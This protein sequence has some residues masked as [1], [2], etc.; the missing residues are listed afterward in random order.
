MKEFTPFQIIVTGLFA[1]LAVIGLIVFATSQGGGK[2]NEAVGTVVIWGTLPTEVIEDGIATLASNQEAYSDVVYV[3]QPAASFSKNLSDALASGTGPDLVL[4]TQEQLASERPK[5]QAIPYSTFPQ[6]DYIDSYLPLFELFLAGEGVYGIPFA[7]DPLV[8]YYNRPLL[9]SAGIAAP[10]STWEAV[11][12]LAP[13]VSVREGGTLSR[14]LIAFGEYGNVRNARAIISLLLLQAGT[15]ITAGSETGVR[16][17]FADSGDT[18]YGVTPAQSAVSYYAQ[19]ADPA[20]TLYSWNRSLPDSRSMFVAGDLALYPGFVSELPYLREA[21]P[22]LDFDMAAIP[23]PGAGGKRV[24]YGIGY[25]FSIPKAAGNPS[26]AYSVALALAAPDTAPLIA[27]R[28]SM[29]PALRSALS[30]RAD[31][32][33][34]PVYFPQ[35]LLAAGWLSPAPAVTDSAF[36]A[37]IGDITSGR[38]SIDQA[39]ITAA[40]TLTAALR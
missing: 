40:Q 10:P 34:T 17:V 9:T 35:A 39:L 12:G 30:P 5:L 26:G 2:G 28:L 13:S 6:R 18:S 14:S 4:L 27:E 20:K 25:A 3:E 1:F 37:M 15:P 8:L 19:F 36:S 29:A 31:D 16:A 7:I 32:R 23:A 38:K 21:N 33:F 22:N 11:A 24:T